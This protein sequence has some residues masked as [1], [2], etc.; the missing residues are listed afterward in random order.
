MFCIQAT[1]KTSNP[2][3]KYPRK[4]AMYIEKHVHMLMMD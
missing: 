4:N 1:A 3:V 2:I